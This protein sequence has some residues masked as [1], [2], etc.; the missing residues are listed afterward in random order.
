M[1][2]REKN[3]EP[4]HAVIGFS[5]SSVRW[6][7]F[8]AIAAALIWYAGDVLL[9]TFAGALLGVIIR[10]IAEWVHEKKRLWPARI[11]SDRAAGDRLGLRSA[12]LLPGPP[13]HQSSNQISQAIPKP[14]L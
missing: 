8:F 12:L 3:S 4:V 11:L 6:F 9:M 2:L 7:V 10:A 5:R 1:V 14:Y 13:R